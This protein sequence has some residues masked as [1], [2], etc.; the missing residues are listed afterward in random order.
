[1]YE[2]VIAECEM[3]GKTFTQRGALV[4]HMPMHTGERPHQV[5]FN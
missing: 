1:M 4:R 2:L 5:H 3:C